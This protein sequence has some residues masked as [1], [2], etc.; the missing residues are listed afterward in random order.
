[1]DLKETSPIPPASQP[2]ASPAP[3]APRYQSRLKYYIHDSIGVLRLELTGEL[4]EG[5]IKELTGCWCTARTTLGNRKL[6]LDLRRLH[7]VDAA[8]RQWLNE[9]SSQERATFLPDRPPH[10]RASATVLDLH[11]ALSL[12]AAQLSV[13]DRVVGFC[14]GV[15]V[16]KSSTPTP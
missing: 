2:V 1:M 8:G 5:D 4:A 7:T 6:V 9:M 10:L 15:G 14:R 11:N 16:A 12:P 3:P 13:W